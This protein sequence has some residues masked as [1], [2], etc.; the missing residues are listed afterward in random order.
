MGAH[1]SISE[2]RMTPRI[3]SSDAT[4]SVRTVLRDVER[5]E[6]EYAEVVPGYGCWTVAEAASSERVDPC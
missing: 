3:G 6:G 5:T 2:T 1:S 4:T